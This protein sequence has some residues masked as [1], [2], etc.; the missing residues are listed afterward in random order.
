MQE[1]QMTLPVG[2]VIQD[3]YVVEGL[4][5]QGGFGA[6]Y[7][8]RNPNSGRKAALKE[9]VDQS[10]SE[11]DRFMVEC[12]LLERLDHPA[13]PE[14]YEVFQDSHQTFLVM[15]YIEGPNLEILRKQQPERR[16]TLDD[17]LRLLSPVVE[18]VGYLHHQIPP[19]IH[20][21][22]KPSN[23]VVPTNGD[24]AVLVDFGIAKEY[25]D[26][27]TTT[28][29]RH[30]SPGY[31]GPEQYSSIGTDTRSDIYG[32]GATCYTLLTGSPPIDALHRTTNLASKKK[33]PLLSLNEQV[34]G[35]PRTVVEAIQQT[36]AINTERRQKTVE[37]FWAQMRT[38][39]PPMPAEAEVNTDE[40][41]AFGAIPATPGPSIARSHRKRGGPATGP[42]R[43]LLFVVLGLAVLG[44][45]G[46]SLQPYLLP[47]QTAPIAATKK[48]AMPTKLLTATNAAKG[49]AFTPLAV[50]YIGTLQDLTTN[51]KGRLQL[52]GI[53]QNGQ[54][55]QGDFVDS[56]IQ[57]IQNFSGVL[58]TS[59]H[60]L[61]TVKLPAD[62]KPLFFEGTIRGDGNLVGNYCQLDQ[63][64]QCVGEYGIWSV[65]PVKK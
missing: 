11:H 22:F 9:L 62:Q 20:R 14:V 3:R 42:L 32:I 45:I 15:E 2:T 28:A 53:K 44:G 8:V 31:S 26:D 33:D 65:T 58:D 10:K 36:L 49:E 55:I 50:N 37:E 43:I 21:D 52:A 4:L 25:Y 56:Q 64:S 18:A 12:A 40:Y 57:G 1:V 19:I 35:L 39:S 46:L 51:Q 54:V 61:F 60:L 24:K 34:P 41:L 47:R 38:A 29:V 13:L 23:I 59:K 27:A 17:M 30:C 5:G 16:Y 48:P 7:L 63:A 6:V